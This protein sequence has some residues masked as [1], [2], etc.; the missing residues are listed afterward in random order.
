MSS[1]TT[2]INNAHGYFGES[3]ALLVFK[4][5]KEAKQWRRTNLRSEMVLI[6]CLKPGQSHAGYRNNFKTSRYAIS[7]RREELNLFP[8]LFA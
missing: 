7:Y 3:G 2:K 1:N 8:N 4:T 5:L 6:A